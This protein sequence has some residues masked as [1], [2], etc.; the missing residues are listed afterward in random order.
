MSDDWC[1]QPHPRYTPYRSFDYLSERAEWELTPQLGRVALY[2]LGLTPEEKAHAAQLLSESLVVDLHE[3]VVVWPLDLTTAMDYSRAGRVELA[4]EGLSRSGIDVVID[5]MAGPTGRINSHNGWKW[6]DVLHDLGMRLADVAHQ[7]MVTVARS[8]ADVEAAKQAGQIALVFGMEGAGF[9]ENEL[10]R[11]DIIYGFGVRQLGLVYNATNM[12]GGGMREF[13]DPGLTLFGREVVKRMNELGMSI[14]LSHAGDRTSLDTIEV[15]EQPVVIS[16]AGA[17]GVWPSDRMKPDVV[18]RELAAAGGL[19]GVEA[20][21]GSTLVPGA[22]RHTI[23]EVMRHF[24]YCVELMGIDH[25]TFGPDTSYVDHLGAHK[26]MGK[27]FAKPDV[28]LPVDDPLT[29]IDVADVTPPAGLDYCHGLENPTENFPNI[30]GWLV[31]HGYA[32]DDIKKVI[33]G[34][35]QRVL[36][37]TWCA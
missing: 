29:R 11:L 14:D 24:E 30:V 18:L 13:R 1:C 8:I 7:S 23:D 6:D 16:H 22:E 3:H 2:D 34:N 36:A 26:A 33:G 21:A 28:V 10:D 25:V 31:Q 9:V 35:S 19:L 4:Y 15:S 12:I 27:L 20:V 17:R 32:D 37:E 5:N